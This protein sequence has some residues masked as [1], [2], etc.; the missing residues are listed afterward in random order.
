MPGEECGKRRGD[1]GRTLQVTL[2]QRTGDAIAIAVREVRVGVGPRH[3]PTVTLHLA[4]ERRR[5]IGAT[6]EGER[7]HVGAERDRARSRMLGGV[8]EG[9]EACERREQQHADRLT[10]GSH[11]RQTGALDVECGDVA[12]QDH[13]SLL[14]KARCSAQ[15]I[16]IVG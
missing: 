8:E 7:G 3:R 10:E 16:V 15:T 11:D 6:L 2:D 1:G 14:R 9:L 5:K 13:A 12:P 4:S